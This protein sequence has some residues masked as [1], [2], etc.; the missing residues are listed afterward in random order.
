MVSDDQV[1]DAVAQQF[2]AFIVHMY[3]VVYRTVLESQV[4]ET[5]I[6]RSKTCDTS[7]APDES[8]FVGEVE[9]IQFSVK[10]QGAA[11]R[12]LAEDDGGVVSTESEGIA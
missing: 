7:D 1:N 3:T 12:D 9:V 10:T 8:F 4:V 2:Q 5:S 11:L 6:Y